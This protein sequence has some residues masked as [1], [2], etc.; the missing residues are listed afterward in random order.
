MS[1]ASDDL[2]GQAYRAI[3][4][5]IVEGGLPPGRRMSHRNL[6]E[7]L[8]IGRSPVRDA[9]LQLEAEGLVVQRAQRGVLLR[10]LG[11]V[12][13]LMPPYVITERETAWLAGQV[14]D[15]LGALVP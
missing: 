12:L 11:N 6:S 9:I 10:P 7:R 2:T 13:Y 8:G 4:T 1:D 15:V 5:M 14:A 3:R